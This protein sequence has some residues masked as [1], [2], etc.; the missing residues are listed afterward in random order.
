MGLQN[1]G[2]YSEGR[3]N[4]SRPVAKFLAG[5]RGF[6]ECGAVGLPLHKIHIFGH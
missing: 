4:D 2:N 5:D 6:R 1:V 3:G